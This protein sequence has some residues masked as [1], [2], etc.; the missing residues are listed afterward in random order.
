MRRCPFAALGLDSDDMAACPGY[1]A[2]VVSFAGLALGRGISGS[3]CVNMGAGP[4]VRGYVG[5]CFHPEAERIV[6]EAAD[7]CRA[8][9]AA[10]R[11]RV[12]AAP[13][14]VLEGGGS[15]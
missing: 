9:V 7:L 5:S 10:I 1:E 4:G 11:P 15:G 12:M 6:E 14:M 2:E 13:L 8:H 3:A